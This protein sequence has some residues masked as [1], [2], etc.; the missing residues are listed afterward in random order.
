MSLS[1]MRDG[2][3]PQHYPSWLCTFTTEGTANVRMLPVR[4]WL[5]TYQMLHTMIET[6]TSFANAVISTHRE[7]LNDI[8]QK[9]KNIAIYQ[10][11]TEH[12]QQE[13]AFMNE[14]PIECTASGSVDEIAQKLEAHFGPHKEQYPLLL[15]DI[16]QVLQ[17][18]KE[19]SGASSFR[20]LLSSV[21]NNM[22]RKFHTDIN[23]LRLLCTYSG[24]GTLWLP[25]EA[26]EGTDW[27]NP[28]N[29]HKAE[30]QIQQVATGDVVI[31]K[32]ALY[33][34]SNAILH[35]SP[36]IEASGEKRFLLRIDTNELLNLLS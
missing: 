9:A 19:C 4:Q 33:D 36:A 1:S 27:Q 12:L 18:F 28:E 17:L 31:L 20:L 13:L 5:S 8:H 16:A 2:N 23:D 32:G 29:Y 30:D 34:D 25:D 21:K 35:R 3:T 24:Q 10:R 26:V 7:S 11:N 22:C 15:K 6:Q 14:Q